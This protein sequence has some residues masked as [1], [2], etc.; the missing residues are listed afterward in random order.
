ME[1]PGGGT[2]K[3]TGKW[4]ALGHFCSCHLVGTTALPDRRLQT[5]AFRDPGAGLRMQYN[6]GLPQMALQQSM[7]R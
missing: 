5:Q 4:G 2:T 7:E 3:S 6:R 1:F